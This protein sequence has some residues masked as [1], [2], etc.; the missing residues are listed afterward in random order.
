MLGDIDHE[1]AS[2]FVSSFADDT[3]VLGKV[4]NTQDVESLQS[5]L[6]II[7]Q[8]SNTNNALFNSD[9]FECLRYGLNS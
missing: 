1:V 5:D 3:R 4:T 7:Y 6:Y 8:W 9:K 2:A